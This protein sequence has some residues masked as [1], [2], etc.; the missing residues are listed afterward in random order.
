MDL[1]R[2]NE[3]SLFLFRRYALIVIVGV[4]GLSLIYGLVPWLRKPIIREHNFLET[5][6]AICFVLSVVLSVYRIPG[7]TPPTARRIFAVIPV[8]AMFGFLEEM[9]YGLI[10]AGAS[11]PHIFDVQ[12]DS[13]HDLLLIFYIVL[14]DKAPIWITG[15]LVLI[16]L[17]LVGYGVII[18]RLYDYR[19]LV[20]IQQQFPSLGFVGIC[21]LFL[22]LAAGLDLEIV[23]N[24]WTVLAEELLETAAS[25]AMIFAALAIPYKVPKSIGSGG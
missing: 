1:L 4:I 8:L 12:I 13:L 10:L 21:G 9:S 25:L 14:R 11:T 7:V 3:P 24:Q 5:L 20:M 16:M 18:G 15:V 6:T 2:G 19:T 17:L 23:V 22:I